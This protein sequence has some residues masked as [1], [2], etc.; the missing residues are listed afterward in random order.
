[1]IIAGGW[2]GGWMADHTGWRAAFTWLAAVGLLYAPV[3]VL[4][5]RRL[6]GLRT[7]RK[8]DRARPGDILRSRCYLALAVAFFALCAMLWMFYAWLPSFIYE[9]YRLSMAESG[10]MATLYLQS[11]TIAGLLSGGALAD[12]A[13]KRA[14]AGR[15]YISA[16]GL[17]LCAPFAWLTLA[18]RTL[19]LLKIAS[20]G[21]GFF[22]A[23]MMANIFASS[24][25]VVAERNYGL[26]AGTLNMI[27]GV[28]G[29]LAMFFA[30]I[31]K[32]SF[33]I[34]A[35]MLWVALAAAASAVLLM[36]VVRRRFEAD[37]LRA[38]IAFKI[39]ES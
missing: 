14:P 9:R 12:W 26:A 32:E 37:R 18:V 34:E 33:G 28:A 3:L 16:L 1:G 27:G 2:F 19:A 30:G 20:A 31:W 23:G 7:E 21:F 38:R 29:G 35:L 11:S 24:Y 4:F 25:D 8:Q 5:F 39:T 36:I 6:P 22:A 15:F 10:L 13:V 17:L